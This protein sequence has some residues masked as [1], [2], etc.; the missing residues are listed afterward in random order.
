[1]LLVENFQPLHLQKLLQNRMAGKKQLSFSD[2]STPDTSVLYRPDIIELSSM[3][4]KKK[5]TTS[6][7]LYPEVFEEYNPDL[8]FEET[9]VRDEDKSFKSTAHIQLKIPK[10]CLPSHSRQFEVQRSLE[11]GP[12]SFDE[13]CVDAKQEVNANKVCPTQTISNNSDLQNALQVVCS[14]SPKA[15]RKY[16]NYECK[17]DPKLNNTYFA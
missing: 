8:S 9:P 15:T 3:K 11:K 7:H 4:N 16:S 5:S 2:F 10:H 12:A 14:H 1:M 17:A 6:D 13:Q